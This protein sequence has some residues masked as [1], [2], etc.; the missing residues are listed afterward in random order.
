MTLAVTPVSLD[1]E[2]HVYR[3][4]HGR[5]LPSVTQVLRATIARGVFD[6]V[7]GEV[8]ERK[9]RLGAAV[10]AA[11]QHDAAGGLD[12]PHFAAGWPEAVPY[13][14]AWRRF[15]EETP[16]F[17]VRHVERALAH[18]TLGFAGTAD[19]IGEEMAPSGFAAIDSLIDFKTG[20]AR[21][22]RYQLAAYVE[23]ARANG[24]L[25]P[26]TFV[27]RSV[28]HLRDDGT[29]RRTVCTDPQQRDFTTFQAALE[30]FRNPT[31]ASAA[32]RELVAHAQQEI[33][34]DR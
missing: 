29:Y 21:G 22:A 3:D 23:L 16:T 8:L 4:A 27:R 1:R 9:G 17:T 12:Y 13:F 33:R 28:L 2:F 15:L 11:V 25:P 6:S 31:T 10:H 14:D 24:L 18:P 7:R 32:A 30:V 34:H 19:V 20:N 26:Y 5:E